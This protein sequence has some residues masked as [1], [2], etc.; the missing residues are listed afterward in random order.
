MTIIDTTLYANGA[1]RLSRHGAGKGGNVLVHVAS[2]QQVE[3]TDEG[4]ERIAEVDQN[5]ANS[6]SQREFVADAVQLYNHMRTWFAV[7]APAHNDGI[8]QLGHEALTGQ[9]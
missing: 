8:R 9:R 3:I 5:F 7:P 2:G 6:N 1:L 4:A